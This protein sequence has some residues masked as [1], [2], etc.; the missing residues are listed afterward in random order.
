MDFILW[1]DYKITVFLNSLNTPLLD[2]IF[3]RLTKAQYWVP[4]FLFILFRIYKVKQ[5]WE[6]VFYLLLALAGVLIFTDMISARIFK[7]LFKRLRPCNHPDVSA[8]IHIVNNYCSQ[9]YSFVSS[10]A[11]NSFGIF[12]VSYFLRKHLPK[13]VP[14]LLLAWSIIFSYTRI[15]LGVHFVSDII[16][17]FIVGF[18]VGW[19][20]YKFVLCK[21]FNNIFKCHINAKE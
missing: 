9:A 1:L 14:I 18:I 10:H 8:Y 11:T 6:T 15:Y 3:Y 2:E 20:Y 5:D 21:F 4:L 7:P 17:G 16:G 19:T 12:S 13:E